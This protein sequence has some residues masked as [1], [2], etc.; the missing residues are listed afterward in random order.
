M[1]KFFYACKN[2]YIVPIPALIEYQ[3][4]ALFIVEKNI[5]MDKAYAIKEYLENIPH[6]DERTVESLIIDNC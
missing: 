5:D 2:Q 1:L 3:D 6:N 4:G